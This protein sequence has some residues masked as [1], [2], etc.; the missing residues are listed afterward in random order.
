MNGIGSGSRF[1]FGF[2][3]GSESESGHSLRSQLSGLYSS[4]FFIVSVPCIV[5]TLNTFQ[6]FIG[7]I[8]FSLPF[9][10]C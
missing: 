4:T 1:R 9:G 5:Y 2:G 7:F 3:S 8:F 10:P 6:F